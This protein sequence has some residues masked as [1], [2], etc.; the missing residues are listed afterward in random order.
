MNRRSQRV[1]VAGGFIRL[2]TLVLL[3]LVAAAFLGSRAV[4]PIVSRTWAL[5]G[6]LRTLGEQLLFT[7]PARAEA[8]KAELLTA[9][10]KRYGIV[11]RRSDLSVDELSANRVRLTL[12]LALPY[13]LPFDSATR[14]YETTIATEVTRPPG[15]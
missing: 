13:T 9:A 6:E 4:W 14:V 8:A 5:K 15:R 12:R 2:K 3:A 7:D 1:R 11:L 10:Y